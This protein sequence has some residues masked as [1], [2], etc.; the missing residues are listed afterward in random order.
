[1]VSQNK[2]LTHVRQLSLGDLVIPQ[3][4]IH[5][6]NIILSFSPPDGAAEMERH[7]YQGEGQS[8]RL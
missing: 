4:D 2:P 6:M 3:W 7:N 5:S 1:M 8:G